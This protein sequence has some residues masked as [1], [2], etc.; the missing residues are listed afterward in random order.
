MGGVTTRS[1]CRWHCCL[2]SLIRCGACR[3]PTI[4]STGSPHGSTASSPV[5]SSAS[6]NSPNARSIDLSRWACCSGPP[7]CLRHRRRP[8]NVG[9][10]R[11]TPRCWLAATTAVASHSSAG[12]LWHS[13]FMPA[14]DSR[15]TVHRPV[16]RVDIPGAS[17]YTAPSCSTP[18]M[19]ADRDGVPCTCFE[20]TLCDS[21]TQ[22]SWLQHGTCRSTTDCD[23]CHDAG[24][25]ARLCRSASTRDR[26]A[27]CRSC[28]LLAPA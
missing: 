27:A 16:T 7:W 11:C 13:G 15:L 8:A 9:A 21:T 1:A 20:R 22:L 4:C 10:R 18:P 23:A 2:T 17:S 5:A 3:T 19:Y 25:R 28:S 12:R 6:A 24:P 14:T 26:I